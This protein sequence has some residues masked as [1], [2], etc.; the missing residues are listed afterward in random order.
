MPFLWCL[1]SHLLPAHEQ[2][3]R[4]GHAQS[5]HNLDDA[6]H[7]DQQGEFDNLT[8]LQEDK[9]RI[10]GF[11]RLLKP[12]LLSNS[13]L[14]RLYFDIKD[15]VGDIVFMSGSGS[16]FFI[17]CNSLPDQQ[18]TLKTL[19]DQFSDTVQLVTV[20]SVTN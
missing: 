12:A 4:D 15:T 16:T 6:W 17:S 2:A 20:S 1:V 19:Q 14:E 5:N 10:L 18:N 7:E 8:Q 9:L 3:A 13:R 11:N